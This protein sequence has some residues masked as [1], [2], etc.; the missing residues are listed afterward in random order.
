MFALTEYVLEKR[1]MPSSPAY[2]RAMAVSPEYVQS[3]K[4]EI[5]AAQRNI[6][7]QRAAN[8]M[9]A[10]NHYVNKRREAG[11]EEAKMAPLY[12]GGIGAA[13]GG[14]LGALARGGKGGIIGGLTGAA[15]GAGAGYLIRN[16]QAKTRANE[17]RGA[18]M[19][20]AKRIQRRRIN[21]LQHF[22]TMHGVTNPGIV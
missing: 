7:R 5:F 10:T 6:L 15:L 12:S 3:N 13:V 1:A 2:E 14:G 9:L 4:A 22:N 8:D 11:L 17:A 21:A 20:I 16:N 19:S 18:A